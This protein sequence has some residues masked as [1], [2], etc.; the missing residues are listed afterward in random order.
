MSSPAPGTRGAAAAA[1]TGV[2]LS[3]GSWNLSGWSASRLQAITEDL[4]VS[5]LAVQETHLLP[6]KLERAHCAA[7]RA[8]CR[9][10]HG[11]AVPAKVGRAT[12]GQHLG[13]GIVVRQAVVT[14]PVLP[15]GAARCCRIQQGAGVCYA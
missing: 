15:T 11:R 12:D 9:L 5:V 8:G 7:R 13:V 10:V 1:A 2:G 14:Q 6:V 3:V 4:D